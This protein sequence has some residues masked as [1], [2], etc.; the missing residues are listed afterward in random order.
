ME[1]IHLSLQ[2]TS[3]ITS[4]KLKMIQLFTYTFRGRFQR[5][6]TDRLR[7]SLPLLNRVVLRVVTPGDKTP[8]HSHVP[9]QLDTY[10]YNQSWYTGRESILFHIHMRLPWLF[11]WTER[12]QSQDNLVACTSRDEAKGALKTVLWLHL[13][14]RSLQETSYI[15]PCSIL[16]PSCLLKLNFQRISLPAKSSVTP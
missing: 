14:R 8:E 15:M 13:Y 3:V 11:T 7:C 5:N 1:I 10:N 12:I 2:V 9:C 4:D 6:H 16:Q